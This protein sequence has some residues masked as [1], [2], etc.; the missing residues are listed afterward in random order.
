M[1]LYLD[2]F[3]S[4]LRMKDGLYE[5]TVP[6]L[7]GAGNDLVQQF[8]PQNV[9]TILLQ[10]RSS[11]SADALLLA[12]ASDTDIILLDDFGMPVGRFISTVPNATINIQKAQLAVSINSPLALGFAREWLVSK[13]EKQVALLQ[14]LTNYR[15]TTVQQRID[16]GIEAIN[17][18]CRVLQGVN[19]NDNARQVAATLRG[20]EG[21]ISRYYFETI[22]HILPETYRF[23][24][25]SRQPATDLFNA[26]L[27]YAY[28][29]L[30]R[31]I[32]TALSK[33][34]LNPYIG[35]MHRDEHK[36][37]SL[38]FD[39]IEPFRVEADRVILTLCAQK[40]VNRQHL[41]PVE[42][43]FLLNKEGK[44]IVA[45]TCHRHWQERALLMTPEGHRHTFHQ[46]IEAFA[47]QLAQKV[48]NLI[49]LLNA[50]NN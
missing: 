7:T 5:I 6:D 43:G 24:V 8:A 39:F 23:D 35:F 50:D 12:L 46:Y 33:A 28:G 31:K 29:I 9:R 27:N 25:R 14:R 41:R 38:V 2:S 47:R 45:A 42:G 17:K 40:L 18:Y 1:E 30:Y 16:V 49:N 19:L 36:R 20:I 26:L 13:A 48:L 37:K 3:G 11:I 34:G 32:E 21:T 10:K 15:N 22:N 4:K 44:Q